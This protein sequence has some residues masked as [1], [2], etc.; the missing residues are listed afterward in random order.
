MKLE[1]FAGTM[2]WVR[3]EVLSALRMLDLSLENFHEENGSIDGG[4]E[5]ALERL[6]GIAVTAV[7]MRVVDISGWLGGR[8]VVP[9]HSSMPR[10]S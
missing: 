10:H 6:F 3:S 5:H 7:G 2:F 9:Q 8:G 4:L 1:Y